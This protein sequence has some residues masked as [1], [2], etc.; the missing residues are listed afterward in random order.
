MTPSINRLLEEVTR[1]QLKAAPRTIIVAQDGIA[2]LNGVAEEG[3]V[4]ALASLEFH[5]RHGGL[6]QKF[7]HSISP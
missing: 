4:I 2:F 1:A 3:G 7:V 5:F 6:A